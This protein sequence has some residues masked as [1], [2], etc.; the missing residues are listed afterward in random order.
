MKLAFFLLDIKARTDLSRAQ[1]LETYI[2]TIQ[3]GRNNFRIRR[4]SAIIKKNYFSSWSVFLQV[5][6][7][8]QRRI[9]RS[10]F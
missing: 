3:N 7:A 8:Q 9:T 1:A 5:S 4:Y 2:N 10:T 6:F